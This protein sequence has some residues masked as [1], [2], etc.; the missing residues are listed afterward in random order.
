MNKRWDPQGVEDN[1]LDCDIVVSEFEL[2][3]R[4]NIH[5]RTEILMLETTKVYAILNTIISLRL[6]YLKLFN[7]VQANVL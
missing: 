1:E 7:C 2:Q 3:L 6:E 5:F 4:Y